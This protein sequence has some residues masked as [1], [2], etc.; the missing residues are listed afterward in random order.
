MWQVMVVHPDQKTLVPLDDVDSKVMP[1]DKSN[2]AEINQLFPAV[3]PTSTSNSILKGLEAKL[4]HMEEEKN[5][6]VLT[7]SKLT[8]ENYQVKNKL[9]DLQKVCD[10]NER[11]M[12][13]VT[14]NQILP[15]VAFEN[16]NFDRKQYEVPDYAATRSPNMNDFR[17]S[18]K[19]LSMTDVVETVVGL[20]R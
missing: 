8:D 18:H 13:Q 12:K 19:M 2:L 7:I 4:R 6:L 9:V 16:V 5:N 15:T 17:S 14:N 10:E 3:G 20:Q 11:T 1:L